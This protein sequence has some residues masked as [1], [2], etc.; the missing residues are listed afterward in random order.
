M[1]AVLVI[2]LT[3]KPNPAALDTALPLPKI[4]DPILL[5]TIDCCPKLKELN[6]IPDDLNTAE[7]T[8][9]PVAVSAAV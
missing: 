5:A 4:A 1:V 7:P 9:A 3:D 2:W 8:P 6:G